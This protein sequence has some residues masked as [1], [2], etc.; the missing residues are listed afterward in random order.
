M[1]VDLMD[2][3]LAHHMLAVEFKDRLEANLRGIANDSLIRSH[4]VQIEV[5]RWTR[6]P[7]FHGHMYGDD[8]LIGPWSIDSTGLL[9]VQT[10][11][12][13]FRGK[14]LRESLDV[15]RRDFFS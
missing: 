4:G 3:L 8:L 7:P 14:N 13:H 12:A 2:T 5:I 15:V 11:M 9:H 6:L 1:A 10:P